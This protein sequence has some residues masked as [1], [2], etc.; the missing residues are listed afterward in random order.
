MP[1]IIRTK[2]TCSST[3]YPK[4]DKNPR[5]LPFHAHPGLCTAI[6]SLSHLLGG[7]IPHTS[8][9]ARLLG[10]RPLKR[11]P[12]PTVHPRTKVLHLRLDPPSQLGRGL[13][14]LLPLSQVLEHSPPDKTQRQNNRRDDP[15]HLRDI[16]RSRIRQSFNGRG[17][18]L[19]GVQLDLSVG[20]LFVTVTMMSPRGLPSAVVPEPRLH[21]FLLLRKGVLSNAVARRV[22]PDR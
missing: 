1:S 13:L 11:L 20:H 3:Y 21:G 12:V 16:A 22:H 15:Q 9:P 18:L 5:L 14:E 10:R 8:I 2:V 7:I 17:D 4:V 6:T 19:L